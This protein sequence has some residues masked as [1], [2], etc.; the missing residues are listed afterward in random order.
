MADLPWRARPT[1]KKKAPVD[2]RQASGRLCWGRSH[3]WLGFVL[4]DKKKKK[5]FEGGGVQSDFGQ[6]HGSSTG[7]RLERFNMKNVILSSPLDQTSLGRAQYSFFFLFCSTFSWLRWVQCVWMLGQPTLMYC[8]CWESCPSLP[9]GLVFF[10]FLF[11][12]SS[13]FFPLSL[14]I[15]SS[16]FLRLPPLILHSVPLLLLRFRIQSAFAYS[17]GV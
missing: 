4:E 7:G 16:S 10:L 6:L 12:F 9:T 2:W 3:L 15:P 8:S 1:K 5:L 17:R 14:L 13:F 11:F